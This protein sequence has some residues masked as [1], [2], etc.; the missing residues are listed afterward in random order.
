MAFFKM[1]P[2]VASS[3]S[4]CHAALRRIKCGARHKNPE[5]FRRRLVENPLNLVTKAH[6]FYTQYGL[7]RTLIRVAERLTG[8]QIQRLPQPLRSD[9]LATTIVSS[10]DPASAPRMVNLTAGMS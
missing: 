8:L 1:C 3:N 6:F 7:S 5:Q 10:S 4:G 9:G 2:P